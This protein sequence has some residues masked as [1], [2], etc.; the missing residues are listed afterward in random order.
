MGRPRRFK[1]SAEL[2]E[3]WGEYKLYCDSRLVLVH[4]FSAKNSEHVSSELRKSVTYTI[5]GFCRHAGL[6]RA[7]FYETYADNP[8]Y[9][10][11]I[12]RIREECEVD[13]RE[14]FELGVIPTQ[15]APLWMSQY[16]YTTKTES[17]VDGALPVVLVDDLGG[18]GS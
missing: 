5:S 12:T 15:L 6:T 1:I 10:D 3:A 18:G 13:A 17:R 11:I 2:A 8:A 4:D 16:G 9:A 14:K 7:Q